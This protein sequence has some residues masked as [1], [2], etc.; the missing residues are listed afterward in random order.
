[1]GAGQDCHRLSLPHRGVWAAGPRSFQD[2]IPGKPVGTAVD[3]VGKGEPGFKGLNH[4]NG[5]KSWKE[6]GGETE[7]KQK[8]SQ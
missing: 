7:R 4:R 5:E 8:E 6:K 2:E 3:E 1:M